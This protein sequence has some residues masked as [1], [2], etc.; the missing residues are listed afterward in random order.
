LETKSLTKLRRIAIF[1]GKEFS[2]APCVQ[3]E[4]II[5][6]RTLTT[7]CKA[8]EVKNTIFK[9]LLKI[10]VLDLTGSII[11]S[12]PDCI[13]SLIHLRL[14]DLD[15]TDISCLPESIGCLINLQILNLQQCCSLQS[16][17]LGITGLRNLRR[18]GLGQTPINKVPKG[19]GTLNFLSGLEGFPVG[20]GYDNT[21]RI[22]DGWKLEELDPL[23]H[24][25]KLSM[26]KLERTSLGITS[27]AL[28][29]EKEFL[30][31][32]YLYCTEHIDETYY[33]EEDVVNIEK[34]FEQLIPTHN[35]EKLIIWGFFGKMFPTWLGTAHLSS[36][37]FLHLINC[38]S[39]VHLPPIGQLPNL[40]YLI[41]EG[42]TAVTKIGPEFV[43]YVVGNNPISAEGVAF[44]K[45]ETLVIRDMP[46]WEEW[47]FVVKEEETTAVSKE[48]DGAAAKQ[49]GEAHIS[50]D[51]AATTFEEV[52]PYP[53]PRV[54]SFP[55]SAWTR[56]HQLEGAPIK[57]C[58]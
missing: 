39:C 51:T 19:I 20:G 25:R 53:L 47:T 41:I 31:Y 33:S 58:G 32:L 43:G 36:M 22:Q 50:K 6:V 29:K 14:L 30:K 18:L 48:G 42:A 38:K 7:K 55:T 5:R 10:R 44:P 57:I 23:M 9:T 28:L 35:L 26:I 52:E 21:T 15:G 40:K 24:L 56:G 49:K 11:Q 1:A 2:I 17:P 12:I 3:K 4:H 16:L 13:G 46:N 45:L 37:Q 34:V 27:A 8:F 54:E